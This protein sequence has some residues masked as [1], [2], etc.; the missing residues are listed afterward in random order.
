L[1]RVL[2]A[3]TGAGGGIGFALAKLCHTKGARVLIGDLK[4]TKEAEDYISKASSS[5]IVFEKCDVTSWDDLHNL[6]SVSVKKF[7]AVPDV[8]AP[9]VRQVLSVEVEFDVNTQ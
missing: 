3:I 8:Y 2:P 4:L 6:I 9:I 1:T 7:G 5:E